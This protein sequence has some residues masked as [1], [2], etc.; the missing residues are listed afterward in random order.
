[1]LNSKGRSGSVSKGRARSDLAWKHCKEVERDDGKYYKYVV[2]LERSFDERVDTGSY[3]RTHATGDEIQEMGGSCPS[4]SGGL[5]SKGVRGPLNQFFPSQINDHGK[6]HLP[7]K[8]AKEA[9]KLVTLDVGRFIFENG[10]PFNVASSPLFVSMLRSVGDYG[11]GEGDEL[12]DGNQGTSSKKIKDPP[13]KDKELAL[14]NED[15][16]WIDH[17]TDDDEEDIGI[18]HF[19]DSPF[20][21]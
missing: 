11:R 19:N 6:G 18:Q 3:Y 10:I 17:N 13:T 4:S 9:S 14:I 2:F 21:L 12:G 7:P 20:D 8:D 15:D 1:M 5:S 16:E